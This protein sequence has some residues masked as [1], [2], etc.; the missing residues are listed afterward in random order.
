VNA[1][2]ARPIIDEVNLSFVGLDADKG[3]ILVEDLTTSLEGWRAYWE[4]ST[5]VFFNNELSTKPLPQDIRPQ[6]K[7]KA[8]KQESF[9]VLGLILI[10]LGL[11][12]GYDIVKVLWKWQWSLI[13]R[14]IKTALSKKMTFNLAL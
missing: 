1:S 12:I 8:L 11:M 13:K 2:Q 3:I 4:I 5:S 7:I 6:I 9:D 14:H 10:P